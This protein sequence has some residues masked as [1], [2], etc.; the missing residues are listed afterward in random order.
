MSGASGLPEVPEDRLPGGHPVALVLIR[1]EEQL[2]AVADG[3]RRLAGGHEVLDEGHRLVM[4]AEF[5]GA[6]PAPDQQGF[7]ILRADVGERLDVLV[8]G[9][10]NRTCR[11]GQLA[12]WT[13]FPEPGAAALSPPNGRSWLLAAIRR[14]TKSASLDGGNA[15][16][17]KAPPNQGAT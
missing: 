17:P 13:W 10:T 6:G 11:L 5:V 16:V 4:G 9:T 2:R 1:G 8:S 12:D 14:N 7:E 3:E 15:C